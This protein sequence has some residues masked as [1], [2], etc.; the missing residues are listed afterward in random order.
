MPDYLYGS[1]TGDPGDP[2]HK[3]RVYVGY[4]ELTSASG[5]QPDCDTSG[6]GTGV[7]GDANG[8]A[9]LNI[10]DI[11]GIV[12]FILG[13]GA[14][15]VECA[16]DFNVDG[17][18]NILDIVGMVNCILGTGSCGDG[19][20]RTVIG[21]EAVASLVANKLEINSY[22]GGIQFDGRLTS[23]VVGSDIV[24]SANGKTLIYNLVNGTLETSSFTFEDTPENMIVASS[25][26]EN[27]Q[28]AIVSEYAVMSNYPNPFNPQTTISYELNVSGNME[29]AVYNMLGQQIVSLANGFVEAGDYSMVWNSMDANGSEV[30]SGI[31]VLKLTTDNQVVSNKITLLR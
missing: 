29:L 14:I 15:E 10:L 11:V 6:C 8:D 5:E 1:T 17:T 16:A 26:G 30:S 13:T 22:V 25:V 18:V 19:L 20:A 28:V 3:C 21:E 24:E 4:A 12:N 23:E 31:Y 2:D 27:V 9:T 7:V